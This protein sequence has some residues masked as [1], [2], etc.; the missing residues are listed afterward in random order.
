MDIE[1]IDVTASEEPR[2]GGKGTYKILTVTYK[3][4]D[5]KVTAKKLYDFSCPKEVW[6]ACYAATKGLVLNIEQEKDKNGYWVW[7][8]VHRQDGPMPTKAEAKPVPTKPTY[9]TPEERAQRQVYIV[10]QSSI[11]AAVALLGPKHTAE[12]VIAVARQFETYVM[13][14]S[15]YDLTN[16]I[17][18]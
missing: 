14:N 2:K 6:E 3:M 15:I 4:G 9:E 16:D 10:R 12:E 7:S 11:G 17:P 18:E 13:G 5:G 1:V 8:A